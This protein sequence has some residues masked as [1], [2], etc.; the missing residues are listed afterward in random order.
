M[1]GVFFSKEFKNWVIP[2]KHRKELIDNIMDFCHQNKV[3]LI[4]VP[5]F[6]PQIIKSTVPQLRNGSRT[7]L[8]QEPLRSVDQLPEKMKALL[9]PFQREGIEFGLKKY[10]RLLL[11][12]E[13]GVGKTI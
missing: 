3:K 5:G 2:Q 12:D 6:V 1:P 13:M 9:Y 11:G 10:G 4:D 8:D 7:R